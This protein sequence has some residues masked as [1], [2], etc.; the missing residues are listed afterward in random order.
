[1]S[2]TAGLICHSCDSYRI[3]DLFV[4]REVYVVRDSHGVSVRGSVMSA[5]S[6]TDALTPRHS[7]PIYVVRGSYVHSL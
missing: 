6:G 3:R 1:M 7:Q 5:D 2:S 4:V